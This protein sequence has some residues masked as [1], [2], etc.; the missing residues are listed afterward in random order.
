MR[1]IQPSRVFHY[2]SKISA[3]PRC[4]GNEQAISDYIS[5]TAQSLDLDVHQDPFGNLI[6]RKPGQY[7]MEYGP[8]VILQGHLDMLCLKAADSKHDFETDPIPMHVSGDLIITDGVSLGAGNGIAIAMY[9]AILENDEI[10]H[11]P[12][13]V[14]LTVQEEAGLIG[15]QALDAQQLKGRYL[16]NMDSEQEG[17][18]IIGCAGEQRLEVDFE[19]EH[20]LEEKLRPVEISVQGLKGGHS[21]MDIAKNRGNALKI[22]AHI[23]NDL[24]DQYTIRLSKF[25]GGTKVNVIPSDAR[26]QIWINVGE[27]KAIRQAVIKRFRA[28]TTDMQQVENAQIHVIELSEALPPLMS[29]YSENL[30]ALLTALPS[31]V[32]FMSNTIDNLVDTSINMGAVQWKGNHVALHLSLRSSTPAR[33]AALLNEVKAIAKGFGATVKLRNAYPHWR[34]EKGVHLHRMF[35]DQWRK[36]AGTEPKLTAVHAGLE[37]SILGRKLNERSNKPA[38]EMI[39]FGPDL[40]DA[41]TVDESLSISS[42]QRTY[43]FLVKMLGKL[44]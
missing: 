42:V 1:N 36:E 28:Y 25:E 26:A 14:V 27:E 24:Q 10:P 2:F 16:V 4:T 5:N 23:L 37:C 8:T 33:E 11:P 31:G 29:L 30:V 35:I 44:E 20:R 40:F 43:G 13:E 41:H 22:L 34:I 9:L 39:A 32:R 7:G 19:L 3:I 17:E 15:A 6:I 12:L 38:I 21:G 18:F